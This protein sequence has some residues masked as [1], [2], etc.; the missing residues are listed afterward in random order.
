M[1]NRFTPKSQ[2]ALSAAKTQAEGFGH[3]YIGSEHLLLGIICTEC[4]AARLLDEKGALYTEIHDRVAEISGVGVSASFCAPLTPRCKKIIEGSLVC[5]KRLGSRLVGT[6]HLLYSICEENDSVAA[7]ILSSLGISTQGL[8]NEISSFCE[9]ASDFSPKGKSDIP[10]CPTLS[11]YGRSLNSLA[12]LGKTD[13]LIGRDKAT[14]RLIRIL[15]RRSKNNPCLI[16]EPGVGKTAIVEGLAKMICDGRVPP[17]LENKI[18]VALDLTAMIAG[19]KYRGEFEE[20]MRSVLSEVRANP[21]LILFIDEIHTIMGAGGAEGAIDAANIIKPAL[22]RAELRVI[23]ATTVDEYRKHIEKDS[24][25]ERRFQPILIEEPTPSEAISILKGLKPRYEAH[26]GVRISDEAITGAVRLSVRYLND[27]FLPDKAIDLL[28]EACAAVKMRA[29]TKPECIC[30]LEAELSECG[31]KKEDAIIDGNFS[32]ASELRDAELTLLMRLKNERDKLALCSADSPSV[33]YEEI[34]DVI[35]AQTKIPVKRTAN[36]ENVQLKALFSSLSK[37]IIGQSE[38]IEAVCAAIKRGRLGIKNPNRPCAS[39][40]FVGPTGVGK[41]ELAKQICSELFDSK[42]AFIRFDMSEFSE[43]H[44]VSKLIGAPAGYVGYEEGGKLCEAVRRYP[45]SVVLFDEI[46]KAHPDIYN[47]LLQI[48]DEGELKSSQGKRID[49]KNTIIILT[50]NI[51]AAE[52]SSS[53]QLGFSKINTDEG[54]TASKDVRELLKKDFSKEFLNRLD[55]II[56]FK[57]LSRENAREIC[58][59]MLNELS[60]RIKSGIGINIEFCEE[61]VEFALDNGYS[62]TFGA[63][64]LRRVITKSFEDTFC[65]ELLSGSLGVGYFVK[66]RICDGKAVYEKLNI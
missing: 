38:A 5:A 25:L 62:K 22:A 37:K 54:A 28:D 44:S 7:R 50:S 15:S 13:P 57:P 11:L 27:R 66:A 52:L 58:K 64:E 16:G 53:V 18:I 2:Q 36:E 49:F 63:R 4:V 30:E 17:E 45:Y 31:K 43:K 24:A 9:S 56:V 65:E 21:Q 26:H 42:D 10:S 48:L 1:N 55:D 47:L 3:T 19:T 29:Y 20:R 46:E 59:I 33:G 60:Q 8:K 23:G 34:C 41:T 39:F 12:I 40:L 6:E 35:E 32:Y 61:C 14:E 51:A